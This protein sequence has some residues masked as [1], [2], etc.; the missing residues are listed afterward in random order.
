MSQ[1]P[2]DNRQDAPVV[3]FHEL[4]LSYGKTIGIDRLTLA[5]PPRQLIGLIGPTASASQHCF[6]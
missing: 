4:S 6:R 2:R 1:T 3:E 5:L